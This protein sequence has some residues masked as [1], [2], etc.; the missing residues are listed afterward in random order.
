ML[1]YFLLL[2]NKKIIEILQLENKGNFV[3]N[4]FLTCFI[5]LHLS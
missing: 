1:Q 4:V 5:V 3:T 2:F